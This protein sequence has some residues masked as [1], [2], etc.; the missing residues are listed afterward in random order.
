MLLIAGAA[1]CG[2]SDARDAADAAG[3]GPDGAVARPDGGGDGGSGD[4]LL[5]AS[6]FEEQDLFPDDGSGW[7]SLILK[8]PAGQPEAQFEV[9]T[10][11]V[12][13]GEHAA[14]FSAPPGSAGS[15]CG[16]AS[17]LRRDALLFGDDVTITAS[18]RFDSTAVG[19]TPQL[20]DIECEPADCGFDSSPGVRLVTTRDRHLRIDWKFLNW[21]GNQTPPQPL[22]DDAPPDSP[23]SASQLPVD[24]WFDVTVHLVLGKREA[25]LTEVYVNG[26]LELSIQGTNIAPDGMEDLSRYSGVE[27]GITC[28]PSNSAA[29][30]ALLV[31][32]VSIRRAR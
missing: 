22:P 29:P 11:P 4:T 17:I 13:G 15:S 19:A 2:T 32:D 10:A 26:E 8:T 9:R 31:D 25:G 7:S 24:E 18:Y 6:G 20:M 1:A 30:V 27:L 5:F 23:T 3:S 21:Y 28:N 16:K 14:W 12:H